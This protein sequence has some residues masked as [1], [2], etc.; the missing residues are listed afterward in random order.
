MLNIN[1]LQTELKKAFDETLP[2][3]FEQAFILT[4]PTQSEI[5]SDLAKRF[6]E[7]FNDMISEPLAERLAA[8]IDYYVKTANVYGTIITVGGPVTQTAIVQSPS[9]LTNGKVP[10][11][12]GI[13]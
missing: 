3:A 11:T 2:G 13:Q 10:N 6:G 1:T 4:F 12:L 8:A 9:P 7:A 5:G